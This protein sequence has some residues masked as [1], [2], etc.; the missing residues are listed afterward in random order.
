MFRKKFHELSRSSQA[1]SSPD[2][3]GRTVYLSNL[4]EH[5]VWIRNPRVFGDLGGHLLT[6]ALRPWKPSFLRIYYSL[7]IGL[8][9]F[10]FHFL[11]FFIISNFPPSFR[12]LEIAKKRWTRTDACCLRGTNVRYLK[13]PAESLLRNN[14]TF[15]SLFPCNAAFDVASPFESNSII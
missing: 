7:Q 8:S 13:I 11:F 1:T 3:F 12:Y 9:F 5:N 15:E 14:V 2:T 10:F 4:S 6:H